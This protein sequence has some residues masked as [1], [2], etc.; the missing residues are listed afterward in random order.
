MGMMIRDPRC[1]RKTPGKGRRE[2]G[3]VAANN[4]GIHRDAADPTEFRGENESS[5]DANRG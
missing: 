4:A 1:S 2:K 5:E 3:S